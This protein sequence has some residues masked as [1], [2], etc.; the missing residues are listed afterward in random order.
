[1]NLIGA[2]SSAGAAT[3]M[4]LSIAPCSSSVSFTETTVAI[5]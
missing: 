4:Q 5:R 2:A 1:M 3:M